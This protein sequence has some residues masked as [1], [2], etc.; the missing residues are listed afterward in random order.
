MHE[1]LNWVIEWLV[2]TSSNDNECSCRIMSCSLHGTR[3]CKILLL[4]G[5]V[6]FYTS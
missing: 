1:L 5:A 3:N 4:A 6:V 2:I